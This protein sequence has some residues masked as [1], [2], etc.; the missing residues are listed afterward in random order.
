M[1]MAH[2]EMAVAGKLF[3]LFG[4]PGPQHGHRH[5]EEIRRSAYKP[6]SRNEIGQDNRLPAAIPSKL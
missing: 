6:L 2:P 4:Q 3:S 1:K 5:L